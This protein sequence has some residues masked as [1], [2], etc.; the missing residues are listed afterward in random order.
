MTAMVFFATVFCSLIFCIS[1]LVYP[2]VYKGVIIE[3]VDLSGRSREEVTQLLTLW[4]K[5][6]QDKYIIV[7]Y[8]D[9]IFKVDASSIELDIDVAAT[10][11]EVC[12]Y[13]RRGSWWE[14]IKNIRTAVQDG[15]PVSLDIKYNE[16]KL[17]GLVE[18]WKSMIEC[19]PRNATF[20]MVTGKIAHQEPGYKLESNVLVPLIVE[21][22][23]K[24][25]MNTVT[26][27]VQ[28]LYPE[29]TEEDIV[30]TGIHETLSTY[31]TVFN[32]QDANRTENIKLAAWK[33]NGYIVYP[34]KVFSFNEV[35]GPREKAYG[36]KEALE[37]IDGEYVPGIGGGICQ[38]SSTLYNAAIL[39]NLNIVE[40][41][42]HSKPLSYVPIGRDATV[43]FG[44]LDFKFVNNTSGPLMIMAEVDGN[45]L[46]VGILG[47]QP[48]SEKI[49]IKTV[50][51]ETIQ[52]EIIKKKDAN[53][54][55]GETKIDKQGKPGYAVTT[56]RV[57]RPKGREV[58]QEV[59]SNDVYLA[60]DTI[61]KVGT[62][63][64][65]FMKKFDLEQ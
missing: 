47:Q 44:E 50:N 51:Q 42:N 15:Y 57:V 33:T 5:E 22:F 36:F 13:G 32:R 63:I 61:V 35:V 25:E 41:Y 20:N 12:T 7:N 18:Q 39:A 17:D 56:V 52:P 48:L 19:P 31:T 60:D 27:P 40:R 28:T 4:Q 64:P 6:Y 21:A 9:K 54:Y 1:F 38:V 8:R 24:S 45:K 29:T 34:G 58:T 16:V 23:R 10:V 30:N 26:L 2:Y 62:Q 49:E 53:L 3:G 14:R 37:I 11:D 55:I 65:P 59:L 43:F 46:V